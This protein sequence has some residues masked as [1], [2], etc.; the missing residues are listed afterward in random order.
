M[1]DWQQSHLFFVSEK[2]KTRNLQLILIVFFAVKIRVFPL[3]FDMKPS[4]RKVRLK[5]VLSICLF[6][7]IAE[8]GIT[9]VP[10]HMFN[11]ALKQFKQF[12]LLCK[13]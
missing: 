7:C 4:R 8:T 2:T 12:C 5:T 9:N 13:P 10:H 6:C 3:E 1:V 11:L